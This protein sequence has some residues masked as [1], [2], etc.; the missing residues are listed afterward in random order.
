MDDEWGGH[1]W[2]VKPGCELLKVS[3]DYISPEFEDIFFLVVT[4]KGNLIDAIGSV[5]KAFAFCP[6]LPFT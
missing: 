3:T 2:V 1:V 5:E 6:L 4:I